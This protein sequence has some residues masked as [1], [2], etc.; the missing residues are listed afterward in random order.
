MHDVFV[1]EIHTLNLKHKQFA[2]ALRKSRSSVPTNGS[3]NA[4][5]QKKILEQQA[6]K[7]RQA[8]EEQYE[9]KK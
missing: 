4:K 6:G 2:T 9:K 8:K 3:R 1:C 7:M 5:R